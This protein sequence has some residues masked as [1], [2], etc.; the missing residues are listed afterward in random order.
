MQQTITRTEQIPFYRHYD[1][2][3]AGGGVAGVAAALA[4]AREGKKVLLIEK[5]CIL[6]G[7]ATIGHI[8]LFV[9]MC[10]GRGKQI[11]A[12]MAEELLRL[13]IRYGYDTIPEEWKSGEPS[14]PTNVR[15]I[16]RFS[17][18]IFALAMT[19]ILSST[20]VDILFD[21]IVT[22]VIM[23]GNICDGLLIQNKSGRSYCTASA[24][25]D[26]TGDADILYRAGVPTVQGKNYFTYYG[27]AA[28]VDSCRKVA[29][30]G[31]FAF[32]NAG[33]VHG[34][35]INLYGK[36][37]PADV[38]LY[39]GTDGEGVSD[40]LVRNQLLMFENLKNEPLKSREILSI[41]IMPQF[42]TTRRI[43]GN[44]TLKESDAYRH[45]DDS[46]GAICDF[47][48]R[49]YLYEIP[50]GTMVRDG[51]PNLITAG[52]S[53]S[54][55]GYAWDILRVIPPAIV[56]GQAAGLAAVQS[57][58]SGI[59]LDKLPIEPLQRAMAKGGNQI[60]FD[61][62]LVPE[63]NQEAADTKADIGHI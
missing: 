3:V 47:D 17:P 9:P 5:S 33:G 43:D 38:P 23:N 44:L 28:T 54:G 1:I 52:R 40:Y 34:G 57:A 16:T 7:L 46:V 24:Y 51:F 12:G 8:N 55:E 42:R 59:G 10:N 58:D 30:T 27:F 20:G 19:D 45:F 31:N 2:I 60:H 49:D 36:N 18:W 50:Y 13:S 6:G 62:A 15:Y 26:A 29:E 39:T 61:D 21:T 63:G 41:P 53:V 11:I 48:R 37:Q 4:A 22:D 35:R 25:I 32:L 14:S 56:S